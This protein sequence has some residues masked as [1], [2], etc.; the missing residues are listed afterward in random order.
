MQVQQELAVSERRAC[1]V[2]KHAGA[3]LRFV[4]YRP[5]D[6]EQLRTRIFVLV[7]G[8]MGGIVIA[9]SRLC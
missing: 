9:A 2:L 1:G 7:R 6:E 5:D 3:T 8:P 4:W